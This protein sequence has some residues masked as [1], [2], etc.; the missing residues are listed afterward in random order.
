MSS[1]DQL[2]QFLATNPEIQ[3]VELMLVDP[4]GV[5]RGKWAPVST[6]AKAF[7]EGVNFPLSLHGCDIWGR[8][9]PNT[10]LHIESGDRD[11]F[12]RAVPHTLALVPWGERPTA[13]ILLQTFQ[14]DGSR[15]GGCSR[16]VLDDV[17][18]RLAS[19]GLHPVVAFEL[20]F[21]LFKPQKEWASNHPEI[22]D[23]YSDSQ[24]PELQRM[25]SLD[26]LAENSSFFEDVRHAA[27]LQ[28]LPIDTIVKE[29]APGQYEINLNHRSD[30]MIAADDAILLRRII[31][32]CARKNGMQ[33]TFMAKPFID[34]PGNGMHMHIS[35]LNGEGANAF[36]S[37][38]GRTK[39]ESAVAGL[40]KTMA[41]TSLLFVNSYNGYRRMQPG[42][43]APTRANWGENN[44]SVAVRIPASSEKAR[45]V[46][47]RIS[48][49]DANP[50]LSLSAILQAML[51]G[52]EKKLQ[53]P[54]EEVGNSYDNTGDNIGDVLPSS[55]QEALVK[56]RE[57]DFAT[58]A[59]G[60]QMVNIIAA[61]KQTELETF[62][63]EISP[64]ERSTYL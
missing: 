26:A 43:Y 33:A 9:V 60:Q 55:M 35:L 56:F 13:Q 28:S 6:L 39:L 11:G 32:E 27:E 51:E 31:L 58:R 29:A 2:T 23:A 46:E 1:S 8:E 48:G 7:S 52:I 53:P 21:F 15:F 14:D 17:V 24:S 64:L 30:A 22:S 62:R 36:S 18:G 49:A 40:V 59:I 37:A 61:V 45:R 38:N 25:Y 41:E 63:H 4:N 12:C 42:S 5:M 19:A 20:E 3:I 44:R 10:G 34:Q 57:S 47:H 54:E 50:Y 16:S